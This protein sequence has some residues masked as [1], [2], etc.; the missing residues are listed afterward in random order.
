MMNIK[1]LV[2]KNRQEMISKL[3]AEACAYE[4]F[5]PGRHGYNFPNKDGTYTI[6]YVR[7]DVLTKRHELRHAMYYF[8]ANYRA[9]VQKLW[10]SFSCE[11]QLT[12]EKFLRRCGYKEELFLDE[13][14]AYWFTE[15]NP[16]KFF[17]L[18]GRFS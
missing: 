7:G 5:V 12:I 1:E 18:K 17:G 8:D 14:Q 6:A 3:E 13:V 10:K 15:R 11:E 2:F 4:G 16:R 9:E